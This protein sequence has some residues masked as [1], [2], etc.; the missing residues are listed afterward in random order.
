MEVD[1]RRS[2]GGAKDIRIE[3]GCIL[4][5][6]DLALRI[7]HGAARTYC[8]HC[9]W[10]SKPHLRREGQSVHVIHPAAGQA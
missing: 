6:G 4:C 3:N 2:Q 10:I 5:G 9:G 7:T 1:T 8:A